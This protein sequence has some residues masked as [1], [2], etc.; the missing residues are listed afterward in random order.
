MA[1]NL[2]KRRILIDT[3]VFLWIFLEP[4]RFS[5]RGRRFVEDTDTSD[6]YLSDASAWEASI[7]CG[8][9][10]LKL[11]LAPDQFIPDRVR[12]ADYSHLAI[13]LNHVLAVH[14]LPKLHRDPFD[15]LLVSQARLE[16]L[17]ILTADPIFKRYKVKTLTVTDIS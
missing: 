6:F 17:T 13:D 12:K 5:R 4:S 1:K 9:R 3:H 16:D 14:S 8:I 11:P 10:K 7:K 15:R 2:K